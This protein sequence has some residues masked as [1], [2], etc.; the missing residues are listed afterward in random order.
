[1]AT[2]AA[3]GAST[4]LLQY[5]IDPLDVVFGSS[6]TFTLTALNNGTDTITF[7]PGDTITLQ[8]PVGS[9][10]TDLLVNSK[11]GT[12]SLSSGFVFTQAQGQPGGFI[13]A[14]LTPATIASGTPLQFQ[15]T[16]AQINTTGTT[17]QQT[18]PV[19]LPVNESIGATEDGTFVVV[20]KIPPPLSVSCSASPQTVGL[21]QPTN[22]SWTAT[23]AAYVILMPGN[24]RQNC[25]GTYSKGVFSNVVPPQVPVTSFQVTAYTDDQRS[26]PSLPVNVQTVPPTITFGPQNLAPI[27][28]NDSVTLTWSTQY[29]NSVY[30]TPTNQQSQVAPSGSLAIVPSTVIA[31]P[32]AGSVVFT[33][34]A[35]GYGGPKATN[36]T[37]PFRPV[38]ILSFGY[39]VAPPAPSFPVAVVQNGMQ[40]IVPIGANPNIY[41]LTA[42]GAGGPL[43]RYLGPGPWLEIIYFGGTPNPVASGGTCTLSW[44]TQNA[45]AATLNGTPVTLTSGNGSTTV[46]PTATTVYTLAVTDANGNSISNQVTIAVSS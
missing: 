46:S 44:Q 38:E 20:T 40:Q 35:Y 30:L 21:N 11:V 18:T 27:G 10:A 34:T 16:G 25:S 6:V 29:A 26:V 39:P 22:I 3:L 2:D 1:M 19:S 15:V 33:L 14:V 12:T 36:V 45:T 43:V 17:G 23:G 13:I 32:N 37:V 28:Y 24:L 41:Q 9:A 31:T 4:T 42:T 5:S 8:M 7:N